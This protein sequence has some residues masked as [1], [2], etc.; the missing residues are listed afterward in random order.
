[1][2]DG[3]ADNLDPELRG[4][5]PSHCGLTLKTW[6]ENYSQNAEQASQSINIYRY[7]LFHQKKFPLIP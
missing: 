2:S 3:I 1:M 5:N 4:L 6:E 7:K